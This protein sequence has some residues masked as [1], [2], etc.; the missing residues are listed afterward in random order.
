MSYYEKLS[1]V[2]GDQASSG[3]NTEWQATNP[4]QHLSSRTQS[5]INYYQFTMCLRIKYFSGHCNKV[6][7]PA[8]IILKFEINV[9]KWSH[10]LQNHQY[11][12]H[13]FI[14]SQQWLHM[15]PCLF[16]HLK[17]T[18]IIQPLS[19]KPSTGHLI[20]SWTVN[21]DS[22]SKANTVATVLWSASINALLSPARR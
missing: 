17:R 13:T 8:K 14:L 16:A 4:C 9:K 7:I 2:H 15:W 21:S 10:K 6:M 18:E 20:I 3:Q 22:V 11:S 19:S 1:Q 5:T 12:V